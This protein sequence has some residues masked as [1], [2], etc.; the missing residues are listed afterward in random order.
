MFYLLPWEVGGGFGHCGWS[1]FLVLGDIYINVYLLKCW[2]LM[3]VW[4]FAPPTV[5]SREQ[6]AVA[7]FF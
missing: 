5:R 6:V 1:R 4:V 7:K 3:I 2:R